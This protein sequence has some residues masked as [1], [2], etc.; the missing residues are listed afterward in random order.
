MALP[1]TPSPA[2][3][4]GALWADRSVK[5]KVFSAVGVAAVFAVLGGVFGITG[6]AA[7]ADLA[8]GIYAAN[9]QGVAAA[10]DMESAMLTMR[11][12][13]RGAP[14]QQTADAV[15]AAF[16]QL[17]TDHATFEKAADRYAGNQGDDPQAQTLVNDVKATAAQYVQLQTTVMKPLSLAHDIPAWNAANNAQVKPLGDKA[18]AGLAKIVARESAQGKTADAE[19]AAAYQSKRTVSVVTLVIGILAT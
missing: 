12:D 18:A 6:L 10:G 1:A 17:A 7:E 3:R 13:A 11:L 14:L 4:R 9:L 2:R 16:E 5:T 8:H 19:A 15:E